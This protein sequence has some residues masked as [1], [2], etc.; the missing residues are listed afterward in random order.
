M[1]D[2]Q[3]TPSSA[4]PPS[5]AA[6]GGLADNVAGALAY[7]TLLP[8][9]LFLVLAEYNRRPFVRF[10]AFQCILLFVVWIACSFL[11]V[12]PI[13]GWIVGGVGLLTTFV[14]WVMSIFKAYSGEVY[15]VPVLGNYAEKFASQ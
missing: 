10:H 5:T 7:I 13:L 9:I 1:E 12:I 14:F 15:K 6:A 4:P 11:M 2:P 8:A 3:A